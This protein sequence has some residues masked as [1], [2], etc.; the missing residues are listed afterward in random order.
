MDA[1]KIKLPSLLEKR[2][3]EAGELF[4]ASRADEAVA[5]MQALL[6]EAP[7]FA[8]GWFLMGY[9]EGSRGR[10]NEAIAPLERAVELSPDELEYRLYLGRA[11]AQLGALFLKQKDFDDAAARLA[12][13]RRLEP[14]NEKTLG[15]LGAALR[16]ARRL[17]EAADVLREMAGLEPSEKVLSALGEVLTEA[18]QHDEAVSTLSRARAL[19]PESR[20]VL[21]LLATA[22]SSAKRSA[23]AIALMRRALEQDPGDPEWLGRL[24]REQGHVCDWREWDA[25][26]TRAFEFL[27]SGRAVFHPFLWTLLTADA[28]LQRKAAD[29]WA[30]PI[31]QQAKAERLTPRPPSARRRIR[32]G[33]LSTDFHDHAVAYLLAQVIE[34][35]DR[36]RFE[37]IAYSHGTIMHGAMRHRLEHGFD[38]FVD[39]LG[40][41]ERATARRISEDGIDILVDLK[42]HTAG[43]R[44][45]VLARRP[46]PVIVT[47]LGY[48]GTLGEG[49]ADYL[50]GDATVTPLAAAPHYAEKLV[51]L[52]NCFLPSDRH[53]AIGRAQQRGEHQLAQDA[54]VLCCFNQGSKINPA[55]WSVWCDVLQAVPRAVLWMPETRAGEIDNLRG[56]L[57]K[58]NIAVTRLVAAARLPAAEQHLARV[59]LAD[60][61]LDT[62]PYTSH[63]TASDALWAGVPLVTLAGESFASRVAASLLRNVGLGDL[64]TASVADYRSLLLALAGDEARLRALRVRL[65]A[66]RSTA[67]LFDAERYTRDLE[68]AYSIMW[69]RAVSGAPADHIVI[70]D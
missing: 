40:A 69:E 9:I 55:I 67:P 54:L 32:L 8:R 26:V 19:Y 37:V 33:Y 16:G 61:A 11:H 68:R 35:H 31:V 43:A 1:N 48:P 62:F 38:D 66:A 70:T 42:G 25:L 30:R 3:R 7:D 52:P 46:A 57:I 59:S 47:Y 18:G 53:R 12:E 63:T 64:V 4:K 34:L 28:A 2:F 27:E 51:L 44:L 50:I 21:L 23:E 65:Q 58:R 13:A 60:L 6:V 29:A 15:L 45:S 17:P 20:A 49:L 41:T 5:V 14:G 39:V 56:E 10:Y 36:E 22:L 24:V